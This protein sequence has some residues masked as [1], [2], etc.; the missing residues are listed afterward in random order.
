MEALPVARNPGW[1][2]QR[3]MGERLNVGLIGAGH[4]GRYHALKLAG[5]ARARLIGLADPDAER[6]KAV[7]WE[8]GCPVKSLDEVLALAQ[9]VIIAAPAEFHF[10]LAGRALRAGKHVLVEKPIAATLTQAAELAGLA[11]SAGLVLQVGH[12]ERFSA[13]YGALNLRMGKPLYIEAV[14][15]APFKPRGTDVSVILDLMIHDLDLILALTDSPVVNVDAVGAPVASAHDDI[16]NARIRFANGA[17]ATITASRISLKT[18]RKMRIF[19]QTG[20][21]TVDFSARK[22]THIGRG[23]GM[24][25]PGFEEFGVEQAGWQDHDA[26]LAEHEAFFAAVLDGAP[27]RVNAEAGTRALAAALAV[28]TS[29]AESRALAQASGLIPS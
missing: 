27:V 21:L 23:I 20:Y 4:F 17:V 18:E 8:A 10:E 14:R 2:Y 11:D 3:F 22:L 16:A 7:A 24:K 12:L 15:I 29:I 25:L 28:S 5:A 13:A 1:R 6:A 26:L 19:S 9:A